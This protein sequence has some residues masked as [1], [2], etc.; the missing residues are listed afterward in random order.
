M[1]HVNFKTLCEMVHEDAIKC[2]ELDSSLASSF[3]K[4]C[5]QEKAHRKAF[6]KSSKMTHLR[7][8]KKVVT[9]LWGPAP[10]QSLGGHLC[11]RIYSLMSHMVCSWRQSLKAFGSYKQ[12]EAWVKT[13]HN[14][15]GIVCLESDCGEEFID[16]EFKTYLLDTG[17]ACH[18]N[19]HNFPQS[20]GMAEQLNQSAQ[21]MLF[22]AGLLFFLWAEAIH[23]AAWL[24]AW[25]LSWGLPGCIIP[26]ER[27]TGCKLNLKKILEFSTIMWARVKDIGKLEPQAVEGHFVGQVVYL[28]YY[29]F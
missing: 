13:H 22:E 11:M 4:A 19:I 8:G 15:G 18:L 10:V 14:R 26:L 17:T 25:I 6:P 12:Y 21:S 20:N 23:H 16:G 5:I 27:A 9:D 29:V 24:W 3:C 2:V 7:Y 1:G 28:C